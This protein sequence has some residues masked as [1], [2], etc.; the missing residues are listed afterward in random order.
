MAAWLPASGSSFTT[1]AKRTVSNID[2]AACLASTL[3]TLHVQPNGASLSAALSQTLDYVKA[4]ALTR[5]G[6][7]LDVRSIPG[8]NESQW[9]H[10]LYMAKDE[11]RWSCIKIKCQQL[12]FLCG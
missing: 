5:P 9:V 8:Y 3:F 4:I 12:L 1:A 6:M 2:A 10:A 11:G 7:K